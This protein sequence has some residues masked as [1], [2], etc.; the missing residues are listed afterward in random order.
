MGEV[1]LYLDEVDTHLNPRIWPAWTLAGKQKYVRIPG[2]NEKRHVAGA[3][4]PKTGRL[5][6]V[7]RDRKN[8]PLFLDLLYKLASVTHR[9]SSSPPHSR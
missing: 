8:S 6:W 1:V 4:S 2:C 5:T 3:L 9:Y 7:E